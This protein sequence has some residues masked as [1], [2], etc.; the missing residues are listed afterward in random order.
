VKSYDRHSYPE[1]R[2]GAN[3]YW[4]VYFDWKTR[5][6]L[7]TK[8]KHIARQ[9]FAVKK[10]ER[11][12]EKLQAL[13][14]KVERTLKTFIEE[15]IEFRAGEKK[16]KNT[17]DMD[18]LA[19]RL[20]LEYVGNKAMSAIDPKNIDLFHA[21][22]MAPRKVKTPTG[23]EKIKKGCEKTT[24][25][26]YI[27]HLKVA[28]KAAMRWG[29]IAENLYAN[30]KQYKEEEKRIKPLTEY[31]ITN[32]LLPAI[33]EKFADFKHLIEMY[34][35]L[36]GRG[37][38]ICQADASQIVSIG[39][40]ERKFFAIP[41]TKTHRDR[42]VPIPKAALPI[43]EQLPKRGPLFPRWQKVQT[44]SHKL[45][46]YLRA[47]GLGHMWLH[48]LR[49]TNISHLTMKGVPAKAIMELVGQTTEKALN[50]YRHLAPDYL[51]EVSDKLDFSRSQ[52]PPPGD[53]KSN[54]NLTN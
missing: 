10:Q 21:W 45:K 40:D 25:N 5:E 23:K 7:K 6:S 12:D 29:Y 20:L 42:M 28:F 27:R 19:L 33:P 26:I 34:L 53:D 41:K 15:Y 50:K 38:E 9:A 8:D 16:E 44:V 4:Y 32:I 49:H 1:L 37:Y 39:D 13:K 11:R 17:V 51:M 18:S 2:Q 43:I 48:G 54:K 52:S 24:V 35:Y 22:L 14:P 3:G 36:G 30:I 46:R 47:C 31:E